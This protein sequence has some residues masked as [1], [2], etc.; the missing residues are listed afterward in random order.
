MADKASGAPAINE[1]VVLENSET[2]RHLVVVR[3]PSCYPRPIPDVHPIGL[4]V[5][6]IDNGRS[7][8]P[9]A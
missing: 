8:T 9:A 7:A 6:T 1:F 3:L 4:K 2:M 5:L